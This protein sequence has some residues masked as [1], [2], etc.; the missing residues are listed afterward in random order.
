VRHLA[1]STPLDAP[2]DA[3]WAVFLDT[4]AWPEWGRLVVAARG[5]RVPGHRWTMDLVGAEGTPRQLRPR[6]VA[7]GP[8]RRL[9]FETR[10]AW[11]AARLVHTFRIDPVDDGSS[12]LEQEFVASGPLVVPLWPWLHAG[13]AQFSELGDDLA[14]RLRPD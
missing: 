13:M 1:L 11:W 12:V 4:T 9:V 7:E 2:A 10:I 3:A 5:E 6:F 14:G 8:G